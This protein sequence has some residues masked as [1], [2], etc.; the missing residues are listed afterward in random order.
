MK[1]VKSLLLG[2][3]AGLVAMTGAQAADLPVKAKP[4]QYVKICSLYGAGFYYIPGTDTCLKVGGWARFETGYGYNGSFTTEWYNN[5][6]NNRSTNDNPWRVKGNITLDAREQTEYGTVRSYIDVGIST[7]INGDDGAQTAN[8]A[9]RWFIQWAGFTIGHSTSFYD[10]YSVGANQYGF[11]GAGSDTGDGGWTVAAYT[12]QFGNGLTASL[13]AEQQRRTRIYNAGLAPATGF[14]EA[15]PGL[16]GV[17]VPIV[18]WATAGAGYEGH[19][20][21]DL[22]ANLRVEQPWGSAQI[23]GALH[24]VAAQYYGAVEG[25]GHPSDK[26]GFAAGAGVRINAP[27]IGAGDYFMAELDYTQGAS[28]YSNATALVGDY[29][30]YRGNTI[31]Y[32]L[33]TDAVFAGPAALGAGSLQLTTTWG[34]NAAFTH[35]WNKAWKSTLWGSYLAFNYND[36]ANALLCGGVGQVAAGCDNDWA[37]WGT[38]LRTEWAVN[39]NFQI[40]LEV[41]YSHLDSA[42]AVGGAITQNVANGTKPACPVGV[43]G[44]SCYAVDDMDNWAVRFRVNRNFYP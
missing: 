36:T 4:V 15:A 43:L 10:F 23:M 19:D 24:N 14:F 27:S 33:N 39:S 38:G 9:N 2:T 6:L 29:I 25:T 12:A 16:G 3:A 32:G 17:V 42:Q 28:R 1:M 8:Y 5:N 7:N 26:L 31:G 41:L 40:G 30:F 21:P 22:V 11:V 44:A 18:P 35:N 13:S 34:V 37:I 20:Y